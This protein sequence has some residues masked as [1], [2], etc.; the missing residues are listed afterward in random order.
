VISWKD[1]SIRVLIQ[2]N[3][4]HISREEEQAAI[5]QVVSPQQ[6]EISGRNNHDIDMT[7]GM[8]MPMHIGPDA[9]MYVF[10]PGMD[11]SRVMLPKMG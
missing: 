10:I 2:C 9:A 3:K 11:M 6:H 7:V 5:R 8:G 4:N 1:L